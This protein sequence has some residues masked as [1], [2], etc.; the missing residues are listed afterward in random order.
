MNP[1]DQELDLR[2]ESLTREAT[3]PKRVWLAVAKEIEPTRN[4]NWP[5]IAVAAAVAFTT[6]A[7]VLQPWQDDRQLSPHH[8]A[9]TSSGWL[10]SGL[11]PVHYSNWL[12]LVCCISVSMPVA[13]SLTRVCCNANFSAVLGGLRSAGGEVLAGDDPGNPDAAGNFWLMPDCASA[14]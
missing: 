3:P 7:L 10:V 13:G 11:A 6:L 14:S 9:A 4:R 12:S 8:R 1:S 2:L 5:W